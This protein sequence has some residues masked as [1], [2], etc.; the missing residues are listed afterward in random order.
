[1]AKKKDAQGESADTALAAAASTIGEAA[2]KIAPAVDIS[3]HTKSV[4]V[5]KLAKKDKTR[6]PRREKQARQNAGQL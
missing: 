1:M 4:K 3:P 5:P 2:G 6:L